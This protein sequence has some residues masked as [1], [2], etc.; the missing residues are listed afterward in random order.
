MKAREAGKDKR[1]FKTS[2]RGHV[3]YLVGYVSSNI[4]RIW[5]PKL[6]RV[7]ITR[8]VMFD[9]TR[10]YSEKTDPLEGNTEP[11]NS[12]LKLIELREDE[13]REAAATL[14]SVIDLEDDLSDT[15]VV[16][17]PKSSG[18]QLQTSG[19]EDNVKDVELGLLTPERTPE[20]L[21]QGNI[22]LRDHI[23]EAETANSNRTELARD[24]RT[25]LV[26]G[27]GY[28]TTREPVSGSQEPVVTALRSSR[29][30]TRL[31]SK[32]LGALPTQ[33]PEPKPVRKSTRESKPS[34]KKLAASFA[35]FK[36]LAKGTE[37]IKSFL[38]TYLPDQLEGIDESSDHQTMHAVIAAALQSEVKRPAITPAEHQSD[39]P[40]APKFWRD[41]ENHRY[42][43]QFK[44][45]AKLELSNL[46]ARDC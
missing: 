18:E 9:K 5:V 3:G 31:N 4:Y 12:V 27:Q 30:T 15:I 32:A 13:S 22:K 7:I 1:A 23:E 10:S 36:E 8:N 17:L 25:P 44:A 34:A 26:A 2:P 19:V 20:P 38:N 6:D 41:L 40:K 29:R 14:E 37:R 11:L 42:G 43:A 45:D 28:D 24:L 35:V 39:L 46:K 16:Q 33:P 21:A